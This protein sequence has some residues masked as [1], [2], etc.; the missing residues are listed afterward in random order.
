MSYEYIPPNTSTNL[1]FDGKYAL[2]DDL[3]NNTDKYIKINGTGDLEAKTKN[4]P[5]GPVELN[6]LGLIDNTLLPSYV[7]DILTYA[8]QAAFPVTGEAGKIYVDESN[9]Y[10]FRWTGSSYYNISTQSF[11]TK[12]QLDAQLAGKLSNPVTQNVNM[13]GYTLTAGTINAGNYGF[14]GFVGEVAPSV[15]AIGST[16]T[17]GGLQL[18]SISVAYPNS[19]PI[20]IIGSLQHFTNFFPINPPNSNA[21]YPFW[22]SGGQLHFYCDTTYMGAGLSVT[23]RVRIFF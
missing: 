21:S 3:D 2:L 5:N 12:T 11:Y 4:A 10:S 13:T 14:T 20:A 17:T 8:T 15:L 7:D 1:V 6:S 22:L 19:P 16:T 23:V 18:I 9:G